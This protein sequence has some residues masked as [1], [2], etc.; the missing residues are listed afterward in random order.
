MFEKE[1]TPEDTALEC[2]KSLFK[3][4]LK[5]GLCDFSANCLILIFGAI[6]DDYIARYVLNDLNKER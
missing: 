5:G 3:K 4:I 2:C 6:S 1:S